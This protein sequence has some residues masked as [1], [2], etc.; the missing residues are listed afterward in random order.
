MPIEGQSSAIDDDGLVP[1]LKSDPIPDLPATE[2]GNGFHEFTQWG[3]RDM[4]NDVHRNKYNSFFI[5][6]LWT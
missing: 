4:E 3:R 2:K 6:L 5:H 1:T